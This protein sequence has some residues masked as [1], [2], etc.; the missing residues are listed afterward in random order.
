M[1]HLGGTDVL[2]HLRLESIAKGRRLK[3]VALP[4]IEIKRL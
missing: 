2:Q 3:T 1:M 4:I